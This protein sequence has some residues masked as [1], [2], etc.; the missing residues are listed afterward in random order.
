MLANSVCAATQASST[1][2]MYSCYKPCCKVHNKADAAESNYFKLLTTVVRICI[3]FLPCFSI[4]SENIDF[5]VGFISNK[6]P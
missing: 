2:G 1:S 5:K 6:R 4:S 3:N